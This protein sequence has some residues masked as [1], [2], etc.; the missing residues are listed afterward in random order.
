VVPYFFYA[1]ALSI[2][3]RL[4]SVEVQRILGAA[5][6]YEYSLWIAKQGFLFF[7]H[8]AFDQLVTPQTVYLSR[9]EIEDW[10]SSSPEIE[11]GSTYII[12]RNG[13]SWKFGGRK[14]E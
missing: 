13:N 6:L 11:S 9:Q 7:R 10:I 4:S 14:V 8:V 2:V 1:K 3:H 12:F 5:P